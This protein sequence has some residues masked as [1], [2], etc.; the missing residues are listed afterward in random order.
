MANSQ[1]TYDG[2]L[3]SELGAKRYLKAVSDART[4][5]I[6]FLIR[7]EQA[8]TAWKECNFSCHGPSYRNLR[9]PSTYSEIMKPLDDVS[10]LVAGVVDGVRHQTVIRGERFAGGVNRTAEGLGLAG[11]DAFQTVGDENTAV[12]EFA[13]TVLGN[14]V[15]FELHVFDNPITQV[16]MAVVAEYASVLPEWVIEDAFK[17]GA[18]KL[19]EKIDV[20]LVVRAASSGVIKGIDQEELVKAAKMLN[21]PTQRLV[22]RTI[23][24]KLAFAMAVALATAITRK[25]LTRSDE[26]YDLKRRLVKL[27][28]AAKKMNGGLGGAM[29]TLLQAQ[30]LLDHAGE[31]S[32]RLQQA[33]PKVWNTL[34]FQLN[35]ANMVYWLVEGML[36]EYVDRLELLEK[37]PAEFAR[38]MAALVR[39]KQTSHIFFPASAY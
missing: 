37:K 11:S 35:G 8:N 9:R 27:R 20:P 16:V 32:R 38:I 36:R 4:A 5:N 22:G 13:R 1:Q 7:E 39:D 24:K 29:L 18:L 17:Q 10:P 19:D 34:R 33:A 21:D 12:Y 6:N 28:T 31:A 3:I 15:S 25:L 23:G 26:L 14:L 30:G 2:G